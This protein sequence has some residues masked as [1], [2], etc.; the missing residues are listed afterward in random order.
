MIW[1]GLPRE[2]ALVWW[3]T[4]GLFVGSFLN[5]AIYRWP[6]DGSVLR[7]TRSFCPTCKRQLTWYENIPVVSWAVQRARCRGCSQPISARYPAVELF[8]SAVWLAL[9]YV[10]PH[11]A[12]PLL[13]ARLALA[14]GLIVATFVDFELREIPDQVSIGGMWAAPVLSLLVP[15]LH[16]DTWIAHYVS[17]SSE[18]DRAGA[19]AGA[20]AGI[21][22]GAGVLYIVGLVGERAFRKEAM[23]FGDVKLLGAI[24]GFVGPGGALVALVIASFLGALVG[25]AN[26]VRLFAF[27]RSRARARHASNRISTSYRAARQLGGEIPFGPYLALGSLPVLLYWSELSRWF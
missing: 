6:K 14:S 26:I 21:A 23:G 1:L 16:R 8:T 17:R 20:L 10:T 25:V 3:G 27:A 9:A 22:V 4:V 13:L 2:L 19:L 15:E 12:W 5:V 11:E 24:G 7:P 18:V